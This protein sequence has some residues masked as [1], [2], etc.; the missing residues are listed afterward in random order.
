M[1]NDHWVVLWLTF[2][3]GAPEKCLAHGPPQATTRLCP[4]Q[5]MS[6][7]NVNVNVRHTY[8]APPNQVTKALWA[9][10]GI[11]LAKW[12]CFQHRLETFQ[13]QFWNSDVLRQ[14][15]SNNRP[16][17]TETSRP[18]AT[19]LGS[20]HSQVAPH[21]RPQMNPGA[22]L[23]NRIA[24]AAEV[25]R[26]LTVDGVADEDRDLELDP[27][28][29]GKP[30]ELVPQHRSD[31]VE[32]PL[33]RD[34]P[35]SR[36]EDRLHAV[37]SRQYLWHRKKYCCNSRHDLISENGPMFS[38]HPWRVIVGWI[39]AVS[40]DRNSFEWC[41]LSAGPFP[42]NCRK[43]LCRS[44]PAAVWIQATRIESCRSSVSADL[45]SSIPRLFQCIRPI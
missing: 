9:L 30:V 16:G 40:S 36:I 21:S 13:R 2:G 3:Y 29:N 8:R 35:G 20:R 18:E 22:D 38:Q 39:S 14:R 32:L 41:C 17:D 6:V 19:G 15:V 44:S 45:T 7:Q 43:S 11:C 28:A 10:L 26:T 5:T 12:M 27:L 37:F 23:P 42:V 34:Q 25:C 24:V 31:M 33:V 1:L 4:R